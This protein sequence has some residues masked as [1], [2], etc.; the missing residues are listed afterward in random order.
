[1]KEGELY[2]KSNKLQTFGGLRNTQV[3]LQR[4][5]SLQ[6]RIRF[7]LRQEG[8]ENSYKSLVTMYH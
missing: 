1:M 3:C 4:N 6:G 8:I 7:P 2:E 5:Q